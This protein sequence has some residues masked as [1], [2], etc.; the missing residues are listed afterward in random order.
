MTGR[1]VIRHDSATSNHDDASRT[2][3]FRKFYGC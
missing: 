2:D 1:D 3:R